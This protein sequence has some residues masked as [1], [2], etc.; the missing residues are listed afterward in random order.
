MS[1]VQLNTFSN[2]EYAHGKS[3]WVRVLW[4]FVGRMFLQSSLPYPMAWKRFILRIFGAKLGKK[5]I[6][7]PAI[8]IK[9]PWFLAIGDYSWIGEG[10][11]IDNL[12]PVTVGSNVCISQ[13][14]LLLTGNHDYT[15]STFDLRAETITLKDGVWIGA[16]SIVTCGVVCEKNSILAVSS[17]ATTHL[18]EAGIYQG[19]PAI[20]KRQRKFRSN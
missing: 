10:V 11:W 6:L 5:V 19:N 8:T 14:A 4:I 1:Q 7:K 3:L 2:P 13:G 17:V 16:K 9:H 18:E 15:R 12:V 20:Y